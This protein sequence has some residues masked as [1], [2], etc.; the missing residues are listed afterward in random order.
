MATS[1]QIQHLQAY[2]LDYFYSATLAPFYSALDNGHII[3]RDWPTLSYKIASVVT[4][5]KLK[6]QTIKSDFLHH[7]PAKNRLQH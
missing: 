6:W 4:N 2:L 7:E 3:E 5:G 1:P